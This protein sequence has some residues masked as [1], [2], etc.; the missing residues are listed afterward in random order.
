MTITKTLAALGA[1]AL[2]AT[3]ASACATVEEPGTTTAVAEQ[4]TSVTK[5]KAKAEK[6][7]PTTTAGQRSALESAESYLDTGGFSKSGLVKQLKFEKFSS[8]DAR[9]AA[10]H[11]KASWMHEAEESAESYM[12]MGGFSRQGLIDQLDFEG[13]TAAQAQHGADAAY[14]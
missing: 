3:G 6:P 10:S 14:R 12:D 8:S 13:F 7:K 2:L 4:P 9:W 11:A 1:A 5:L